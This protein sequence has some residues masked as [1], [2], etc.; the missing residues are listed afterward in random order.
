MNQLYRNRRK[1]KL[2][3]ER[4]P[5]AKLKLS[6]TKQKTK[7]ANQKR[8]GEKSLHK[9]E[10]VGQSTHDKRKLNKKKKNKRV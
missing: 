8:A 4:T 3:E 10:V 6:N 5:N 2:V 1:I 7:R 9:P